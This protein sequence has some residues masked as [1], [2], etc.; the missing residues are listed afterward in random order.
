M[1]DLLS[2]RPEQ[3]EVV[4]ATAGG[5]GSDSWVGHGIHLPI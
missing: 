1:G 3:G 4:V 5:L 2:L